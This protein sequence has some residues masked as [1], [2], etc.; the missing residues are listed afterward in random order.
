MPYEYRVGPQHQH[1]RGATAAVTGAHVEDE[2]DEK[3][4]DN[5]LPCQ[6]T[7]DAAGPVL[8]RPEAAAVLLFRMAVLHTRSGGP[9]IGSPE[10][11]RPA[12]GG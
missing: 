7:E 11:T 3:D 1:R 10:L 2:D 9:Q 5:T 6:S 8:S 4:K 12:L